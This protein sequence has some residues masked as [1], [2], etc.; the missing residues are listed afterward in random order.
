MLLVQEILRMQSLLMW[1]L[2]EILVSPDTLDQL[3]V[4][5]DLFGK[6]AIYLKGG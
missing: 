5:R 4:S 6:N 1:F 3:E 2:Y